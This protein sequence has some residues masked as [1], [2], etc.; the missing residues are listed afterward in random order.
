MNFVS[1][2][3]ALGPFQVLALKYVS[4]YLWSI[5]SA[6]VLLDTGGM[7]LPPDVSQAV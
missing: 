3:V 6:L 4:L 2:S 7:I 1:L 5:H